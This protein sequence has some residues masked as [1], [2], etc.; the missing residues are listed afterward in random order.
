MNFFD[1]LGKTLEEVAKQVEEKSGELL[2]AGKLN[3]EI[4]KQEDAI[5]RTYR[6]IGEQVSQC[7]EKGERFGEKV[8]QL[9]NEI[10]ERKKKVD[11][12]KAKLSEI[13]KAGKTSNGERKETEWQEANIIPTEPEI[14]YY[15]A[16]EQIRKMQES[17]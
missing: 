11:E 8:N 4:F 9:C 3:I 17:Q 6:K 12:L 16:V 2:E 10:Q 5:R 1:G 14:S 7:Y 13:K 15:E